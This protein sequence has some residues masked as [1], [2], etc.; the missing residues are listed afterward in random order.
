MDFYR[1]LLLIVSALIFAYTNFVLSGLVPYYGGLSEL[2]C[3]SFFFFNSYNH[4]FFFG[5]DGISFCFIWL[6]SLVIFLCIF[7]EFRNPIFFKV[8][9]SNNLN[10][11]TVLII[12]LFIEALLI[13]CFTSLD[14]FVFLMSF[15]S[16]LLPM[17]FLIGIFGTQSNGRQIRA[18][19]FFFLYSFIFSLFS[20]FL[21]IY[22]YL[23]ANTTNILLLSNCI[24]LR[25]QQIILAFC[26]L[27]TFCAKIPMLP[28][29]IWLPQ[30]HVEAPTVG[31]IILACLLLK[32]GGYGFIRFLIPLFTE[33]VY[34]FLPI[35]NSL[36]L[37]SIIYSSF[38]AMYQVD[39][40]KIIAYSSISHMNLA[41]LGLFSLNEFS[42]NGAIFIMISH[43]IASMAL[44]L[45]AGILY[46][47]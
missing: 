2:Y 20:I 32:L 5:V 37:L 31:S 43:G 35:V 15:E 25:K 3:F 39:L 44:F 4:Q 29:H 36:A 23:V 28:F 47:Q 42:V 16:L 24:F 46:E 12:L 27:M 9:Y 8:Y 33:G 1:K 13:F 26:L 17:F 38:A 11:K 40:K 19:Y 21:I 45:L 7:L 22:L 14:I 30:A 10:P 41:T 6:T 34:F 18:A